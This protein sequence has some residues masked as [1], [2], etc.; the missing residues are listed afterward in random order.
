MYMLSYMNNCIITACFYLGMKDTIC[1]QIMF[2]E[3]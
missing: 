1:S 2:F 3:L